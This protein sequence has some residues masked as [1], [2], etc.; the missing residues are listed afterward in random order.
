[1]MMMEGE[2]DITQQNSCSANLAY[3][4]NIK[5]HINRINIK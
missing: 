5:I 4:H 1:M 3:I 2:I